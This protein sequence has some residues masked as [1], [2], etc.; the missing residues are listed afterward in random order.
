MSAAGVVFAENALLIRPA[1]IRPRLIETSAARE[2]A[3]LD[4]RLEM[5]SSEAL[6]QLL[7]SGQIYG[8]LPYSSIVVEAQARRLGAAPIEGLTMTRYLAK[9]RTEANSVA[10]ETL[11]K[12]T[13]A[14]MRALGKRIGVRQG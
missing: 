1:A 9:S 2:G 12:V 6:R 4:I 10:R 7:A 14:E 11:E 8:L 3:K 13:L 5:E